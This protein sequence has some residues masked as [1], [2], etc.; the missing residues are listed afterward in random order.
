MKDQKYAEA[1][2][3]KMMSLDKLVPKRLQFFLFSERFSLL[4]NCSIELKTKEKE[5][6][7][8]QQVQNPL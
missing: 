7:S 5:S 8:L 1:D 3:L 2:S 4:E 6:K